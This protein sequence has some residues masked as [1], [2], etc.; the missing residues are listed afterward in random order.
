MASEDL[1]MDTSR[2]EEAWKTTKKLEKGH[3]RRNGG[4]RPQRWR[5]GRSEEVETEKREAATAVK[6][7]SQ[8]IYIYIYIYI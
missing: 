7:N 6:K 4:K 5:L 2:A 3:P 1:G 8:L